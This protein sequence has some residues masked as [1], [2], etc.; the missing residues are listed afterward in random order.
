VPV[1]AV[2][3]EADDGLGAL[4]AVRRGIVR[5]ID[6]PVGMNDLVGDVEAP[7][8]AELLESPPDN[9]LFLSRKERLRSRRRLPEPLRVCSR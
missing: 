5:L 1:D 9:S 6:R 4:A 7:A 2:L 8:V 3:V